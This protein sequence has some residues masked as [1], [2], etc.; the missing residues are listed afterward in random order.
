MCLSLFDSDLLLSNKSVSLTFRLNYS[1]VDHYTGS[2]VFC[3]DTQAVKWPP[4]TFQ[5]SWHMLANVIE[6]PHMGRELQKSPTLWSHAR[7][8]LKSK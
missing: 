2:G 4:K 8:A 7:A 6:H 3:S 5:Q 1:Q